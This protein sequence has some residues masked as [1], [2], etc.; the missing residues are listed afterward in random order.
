MST[1]YFIF[2]ILFLFFIIALRKMNIKKHQIVIFI[3]TILIFLFLYF[4][5]LI[6][7]KI[8]AI[9]CNYYDPQLSGY[10]FAAWYFIIYTCISIARFI[11]L[12]GIALHEFCK[13][14]AKWFIFKKYNLVIFLFII[15]LDFIIYKFVVQKGILYN[16]SQNNILLYCIFYSLSILYIPILLANFTKYFIDFVASISHKNIK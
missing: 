15:L 11:L 16:L 6:S 4:M 9:F 7:I 1:L 14:N 13:A 2:L 5:P 12:F 3:V 8:F 10:A